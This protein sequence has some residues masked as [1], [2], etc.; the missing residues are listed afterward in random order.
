[1]YGASVGYPAVVAE[2]AGTS[3][4][5]L[6]L[7]NDNMSAGSTALPAHPN[8]GEIAF[9]FTTGGSVGART[10]TPRLVYFDGTS[11][12]MPSVTVFTG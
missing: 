5:S 3:S 1:M 11:W 4:G 12:Q 7:L 8:R 2:Q 10:A 9:V 6:W